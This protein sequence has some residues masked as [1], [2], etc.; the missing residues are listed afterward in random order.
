MAISKR[1]NYFEGFIEHSSY[2]SKAAEL[3]YMTLGN[4][5][6]VDLELRVK[7]MHEI[8]HAADLQKH[9]MTRYLLKDFLPPIERE[10]IIN[11]SKKI[12]NVTNAVEDVLINLHIYNIQHI[13]PEVLPFASLVRRCCDTT[14]A[15]LVQFQNFKK[16]TKLHDAIV[17]LNRLEEEGDALYAHLVRELH[18]NCKDPIEL[19]SWTRILDLFETCCDACKDVADDIESIVLKNS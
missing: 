8:E 9:N 14:S 1:Y 3:L 10:D 15:T 2:C 19:F 16:S 11:L 18:M 6:N 17:E 12:D 7:E 13:I 5:E 4:Y